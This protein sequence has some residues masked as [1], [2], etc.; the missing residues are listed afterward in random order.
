M[1]MKLT[2][3]KIAKAAAVNVETIRFYQRK[4]LLAEPPKEL[5]GFR[6]YPEKCIEEIHF[7]KRAQAI[8]FTLV[9]IKDLLSIEACSTCQQTHDASTVKLKMVN[10][11]IAELQRIRETLQMLIGKCEKENYETTCPIIDSLSKQ[12]SIIHHD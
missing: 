11:R 9:E 10:V 6:Y 2:I 8:G 7:I 5:G 1:Q 3:G 12:E 4:G